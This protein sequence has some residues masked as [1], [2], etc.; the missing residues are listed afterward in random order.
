MSKSG[1]ILKVLGAVVLG[2]GLTAGA[3]AAP[4][5]KQLVAQKGCASCHGAKG[6]GNPQA[7]FPR[8]A[9]E[10]A[11]YLEAQL[12]AFASGER[13]NAIMHGQAQGLSADEMV[14]IAGYYSGLE[15]PAA[16]GA[17]VDKKALGE[18]RE[19]VVNGL[20][21]KNVPSCQASH[22]PGARGFDQFPALAG[23]DAKYIEA[24]LMA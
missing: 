4:S 11:S 2:C 10:P 9:G 18:G 12:K 17:Q 13:P 23:Q 22:G 24:Q 15:E 6:E 5:G 3:H 16:A 14:A 19:I 20:W 1:R 21:Q 7:G 8:L